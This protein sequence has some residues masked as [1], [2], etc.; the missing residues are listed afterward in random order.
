MQGNWISQDTRHIKPPPPQAEGPGG[1]EKF[2]FYNP[3]ISVLEL[4][5]IS[6]LEGGSNS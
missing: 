2:P 5:A 3:F 1:G 6:V 4:I